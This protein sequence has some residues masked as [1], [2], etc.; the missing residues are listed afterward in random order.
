MLGE[1][2]Q[3][4]AALLLDDPRMVEA[5]ATRDIQAV[6]RLLQDR[7]AALSDLADAIGVSADTMDGYRTGVLQSSDFELLERISDGLRIPGRYL[8]L[9]NRPWE[10]SDVN[11][12]QGKLSPM[13]FDPQVLA[14]VIGQAAAIF[15]IIIAIVYFTGALSMAFKLWYDGV[16][17]LPVLVQLPRGWSISLAVTELLPVAVGAGLLAIFIWNRAVRKS[18]I[19]KIIAEPASAES[20]SARRKCE[21]WRWIV[22]VILA[23]FFTGIALLFVRF[24]WIGPIPANGQDASAG[25]I[26]P[27]PWWNILIICLIL[28]AI[29]IRL[30]LYFV[31]KIPKRPGFLKRIPQDAFRVWVLTIAF[32]PIVASTSAAYA[33]PLVKLCGPAFSYHGTQGRRYAIGNLIGV[34]GQYAYIAEVLTKEPERDHFVFS[35][36]YMAV[37]PLSEAQLMPIGR[38]ASCGQLA[39]PALHG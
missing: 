34:S 11:A 33:F 8:G 38:N 28:D 31:P 14:G 22:S 13:L 20:G 16:P 1:D 2:P 6:I 25:G 7:G 5:C 19:G 9:A 23:I 24:V 3:E 32:I 26:Y 15:A 37:I 10:R 12:G 35:A 27:R 18:G 21:V 29:A 30:A 4:V 17:V 36:G 39:P